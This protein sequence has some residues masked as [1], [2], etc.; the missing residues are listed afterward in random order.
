MEV[1]VLR[2][3]VVIINALA[4]EPRILA[5]FWSTVEKDA[6]E[7]GCWWW[8]GALRGG[9]SYAFNIGRYSIAPARVVWFTVT[10]ELPSGGK[11]QHLCGNDRCVRPEH[12]SWALSHFGE[13]SLIA[14]DE[15]YLS[16]SGMDTA[17]QERTSITTPQLP[18]KRAVRRLRDSAA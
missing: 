12:L 6:D 10:A 14:R 4:H 16:L 8:T 18:F 11:M 15:G 9:S 5:R 3:T 1:N 17:R 7:G 2:R 13:R